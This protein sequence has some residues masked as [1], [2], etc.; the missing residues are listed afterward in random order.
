MQGPYAAGQGLGGLFNASSLNTTL[1]GTYGQ[2]HSARLLLLGLLALVLGRALAAARRESRVELAAG[3]LLVGIA[4]TFSMIGH[5]NTT[6]PRWLSVPVDVL[7]LCAMATW[8]GGLVML[9]GAVLPWPGHAGVEA[10]P[11]DEAELRRV[12]PVF[13][14]VAFVV[15]DRAGVDRHVR[16]VAWR[17][18]LVSAVRH[19]VRAARRHQGHAVHRA[20]R[21][22]ATTHGGPSSASRHRSRSRTR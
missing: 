6:N 9:L 4:V 20:V 13:S 7:H 16:R 17:G 19:D 11:R 2:Y 21:W 1:H 5:P 22:S 15:G 8:V 14:R 10:T 18:Q 12:L 3:P